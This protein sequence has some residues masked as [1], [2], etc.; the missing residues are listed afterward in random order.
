MK[1]HEYQAKELF[2]SAGI[3]VPRGGLALTAAEA[4][5]IAE[6]IGAPVVVKAQV[7]AG[8]RGKGGGIRKAD[9]AAQ[10][11]EAAGAILGM[12]LVTH[13]TG[14]AG[15]T[16]RKVLVEEATA[17]DKEFYVGLVLDREASRVAVI[18]SPEGGV[19][20][21]QVAAE[22]PEK[23]FRESVD[24]VQGLMPFQA[25]RL[26]Y[27]LGLS[28]KEAGAAAKVFLGL[29]KVFQS[30][31]ASLAEINPLVRTAEGAVLALDAKV[32]FDDSGLFRHKDVAALRDEDEEADWERKAREVRISYVSLDGD[33]GCLVNGA[34][35]AMAT[36]DIIKHE[37]GEPANFLDVGGGADAAQVTAAFKLILG[38]PKVKAILVN[39]FGGIMRCD[40]IANGILAAAGELGIPVPLVVRLEGTNVEEGK[41]LLEKSDVELITATD[42]ADAAKKVVAAARGT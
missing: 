10:A 35:L 2:R 37:G 24:P 6:D 32:N 15:K 39:I 22:H 28:G 14:P 23:I 16:V 17:I 12:S 31:D 34:G 11:E 26:A 29:Y 13:Q 21:E 38:D 27:R 40:T 3:P 5:A 1:I 4:K 36:M 33:I 8:G 25:R 9:D 20:I 19:E 42:M 18:A 7:H 41:A 30:K